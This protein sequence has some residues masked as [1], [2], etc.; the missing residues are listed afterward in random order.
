MQTER[1]QHAPDQPI[2]GHDSSASTPTAPKIEVLSTS[3]YKF[4]PWKNGLGVT[5]EIAIRPEGRECKK[6]NFLWRLS[7]SEIKDTCS[8]SVFPNYDIGLLILPDEEMTPQKA[9]VNPPALLHHNDHETAVVLRPLIPYTYN[10]EVPTTCHVRSPPLRHLT[11]LAHRDKT[12]VT[13]NVETI[14]PHG[15]SNEGGCKAGSPDHVALTEF[16]E[17]EPDSTQLLGQ[18]SDENSNSR[19]DVGSDSKPRR[20]GSFL[21]KILLGNY[22]VIHVIRGAINIQVDGDGMSR[23]VRQGETLICERANESTPTDVAISPIVSRPPSPSAAD[24]SNGNQAPTI[25]ATDHSKN[26]HHLHQGSHPELGTTKGLQNIAQDNTIGFLDA[27]IVII[28]INVVRDVNSRASDAPIAGRPPFRRKGSVIVYD[29][30]PSWNAESTPPL[31]T[32]LGGSL[33]SFSPQL[34]QHDLTNIGGSTA[35]NGA[36]NNLAVKYWDSARHYR[37]PTMSARYV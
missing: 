25:V 34:S 13:V 28:Q 15:F 19:A 2:S 18:K 27:T 14:C 16:P 1:N 5:S 30:Q 29:D 35:A 6:D 24:E 10:G 36:A 12:L 21:S 20:K 22:T 23:S 31:M 8:F 26:P 9:L 4:M 11:I 37:P 7:L 32:S 33:A 17:V 3:D